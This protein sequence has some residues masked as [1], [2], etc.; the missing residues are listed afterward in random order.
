MDVNALRIG[1]TLLSFVVFI[2]IVVFALSKRNQ[3]GFAEA[4]QLPFLDSRPIDVQNPTTPHT[5]RPRP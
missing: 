5:T 1:V 4:R 2:G 3:A